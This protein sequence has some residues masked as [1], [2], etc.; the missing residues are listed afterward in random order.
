MSVGRLNAVLEASLRGGNISIIVKGDVE[1]YA[2][3]VV[4]AMG[5]G[6]AEGPGTPS[7]PAPRGLGVAAVS[8]AGAAHGGNG[9][10]NRFMLAAGGGDLPP[11]PPVWAGGASYGSAL[12]PH[13]SFGSGGADPVH[14]D[15]QTDAQWAR[16]AGSGGGAVSVVADGDLWFG[17]PGCGVRADGYWPL[18]PSESQTL[19]G[20]GSGGGVLL[21]AGRSVLGTG[22]VSADGGENWGSSRPHGGGGGG[23]ILVRAANGL[24]AP[25]VDVHALPSEGFGRRYVDDRSSGG[26]AGTVVF[27]AGSGETVTRTLLIRDNGDVE[28]GSGLVD[29]VPGV[30]TPLPLDLA[31]SWND[32]DFSASSAVALHRV[33]VTAGALL[34]VPDGK[35]LR[36][37]TIRLDQ[38]SRINGSAFAMDV[39]QADISGHLSATDEL[40]WTDESFRQAAG[41][42]GKPGS[43]AVWFPSED[44]DAAVGRLPSKM[45]CDAD[46]TDERGHVR[47]WLA[48]RSPDERAVFGS[49]AAQG[50]DSSLVDGD[51]R[52]PPALGS[53]TV[54]G[55]AHFHL[56]STGRVPVQD[57]LLLASPD[58]QADL[59]DMQLFAEQ[60]PHGDLDPEAEYVSRAENR[61]EWFDPDEEAGRRFQPWTTTGYEPLAGASSLVRF[62]PP[63]AVRTSAVRLGHPR[64][65]SRTYG[66]FAEAR[67]V[68]GADISVLDPSARLTCGAETLDGG[69]LIHGGQ[70]TGTRRLRTRGCRL[71]VTLG[72]SSAHLVIE[73]QL[74]ASNISLMV[75]PE[76]NRGWNRTLKLAGAGSAQADADELGATPMPLQ[77]PE[78]VG[79]SDADAVL[80]LLEQVAVASTSDPRKWRPELDSSRLSPLPTGFLDSVD[81]Q[82]AIAQAGPLTPLAARRVLV[83]ETA[84]VMGGKE[85]RI[86]ALELQVEGQVSAEQRTVIEDDDWLVDSEQHLRRLHST[87]NPAEASRMQSYTLLARSHVDG[88][89]GE[90]VTVDDA[91]VILS[92]GDPNTAVITQKSEAGWLRFDFGEPVTLDQVRIGGVSKRSGAFQSGRIS[93]H[94][95]GPRSQK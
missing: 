38:G 20:A 94:T 40:H 34:Q 77:L 27:E 61:E 78:G 70:M 41:L 3:A 93:P 51:L 72:R 80:A 29:S 48:V 65:S 36:A 64:G 91:S 43:S 42:A 13:W 55:F 6:P 14:F 50:H 74:A 68:C 21:S 11:N 60:Q 57:L 5:H 85:A 79:R 54:D 19:G 49:A 69:L 62:R 16:T 44:S 86:S 32:T 17:S 8:G 59:A 33:V 95:Y 76:L 26:A 1:L 82:A 24:I 88:P 63:A 31:V 56:S 67:P 83:R 28:R 92:D 58:Q 15:P 7:L 75:S 25:T 9:G 90:S 52:T 23:R 39:R 81:V 66:S 37:E 89:N 22:Q 53:R 35:K 45:A 10:P 30:F 18:K 4:S 84:L 47:G 12:H 87:C 71:L 46:L 2:E 73:G